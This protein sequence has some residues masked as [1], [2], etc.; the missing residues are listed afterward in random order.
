MIQYLFGEVRHAA[1]AH[2]QQVG[3]GGIP[4]KACYIYIYIYISRE[5]LLYI[6]I[7]THTHTHIHTDR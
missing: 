4:G 3:I 2:I 7:Y 5:S 6:Y 1:A